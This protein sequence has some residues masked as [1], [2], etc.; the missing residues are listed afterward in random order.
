[1]VPEADFTSYYG[2][3]VLN[4]PT[5][6]ALDI[7]GYLFLGGL[8]GGSSLVAAG[9]QATGLRGLAR[10]AKIGS[11]TAAALSLVGLIHDLGRPTRF[12]NMLRMFKPTSPMSVGSWI[13]FA[14]VPASAGATVL[15]LADRLPMIGGLATGG[16]AVL[17]PALASY[18]AALISNT[19]VPAWHEGRHE[20][21]FVFVASSAMA[22]AGLGLLAAPGAETAAVR[23]LGIGAGV[24]E[25]AL[26]ETMERRTGMVGESF[27]TGR[28]GKYRRAARALVGAGVLGTLV[29][30]ERGGLL[31]RAAGAAL[32][33]GS[34]CTRF[35]IFEAG[36]ESARDPRYT[37]VPQRER[38]D[39]RERAAPSDGS[40]RPR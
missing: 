18:T 20:L 17:A 29:A 4:A 27:R 11:T 14:Y 34:A 5:W 37:I 3:P 10:I 25:L 38:L 24:A 6:E 22:A 9:A 39:A 26:S 7:A 30:R 2:K 36:V 19:A 1:M 8:A 31:S 23:R 15:D 13:L 40:R 32:L 28:A 12:L 35:A 21:P 33:A 16:A